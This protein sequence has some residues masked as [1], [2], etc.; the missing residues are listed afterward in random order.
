VDNITLMPLIRRWWWALL[1]AALLAGFAAN[2]A[3]SRSTPT[4]AAEVRML[5]GPIS[6]EFGTL[7]AAGELGRTYSELAASLPVLREAAKSS[8]VELT[9]TELRK[10]VQ[11]TSNEISR[12]V[13]VSV[14]YEDPKRAA[15]FANAIAARLRQLTQRAPEQETEAIDE[16]MRQDEV[17]GLTEREQ[18]GLHDAALRVFGQGLSGRVSVI[19]PAEAIADP[20]APRVT[21][22]TLL[23][24]IAGMIAAGVAILLKESGAK[25]VADERSLAEL[26][27]PPFFGTMAASRRGDGGLVVEAMPRSRSAEGYRVL[28]AKVGFLGSQPPLRS[29]LV[30]DPGDGRGSGVVAANLAAVLTE[31]G[32]SV[33]LVDADPDKGAVTRLFGL[34]GQPGYTEMLSDIEHTALNGKLDQLRVA[35]TEDLDVLPHGNGGAHVLVDVQ[36]AELL[37]DRLLADHDFV[38]VSTP[39]IQRSPAA[40][41]WGRIT[42]GALIVVGEGRTGS[43]AVQDTVK[44]MSMVDANVLG[45]VYGSAKRVRRLPSMQS[46]GSS[47]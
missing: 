27:D 32:H 1:L 10:A 15:D 7:R 5:V 11:A 17:E 18:D 37:L 25:N 30:L 12:L 39:P 28:A 35:R 23:A 9:D 43:E 21:L 41:M 13:T 44:S 46:R 14:Q 3:A 34:E 42:D 36:R 22:I 20:V 47:V 33:L 29:L 38:I 40:L 45:T 26:G 4:Y 24:A 19:D 16:L 6:A 31:A 8:G 2:A